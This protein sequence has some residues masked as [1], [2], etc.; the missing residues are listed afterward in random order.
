VQQPAKSISPTHPCVNGKRRPLEIFLLRCLKLQRTVRPLAVV[1]TNVD[2]E[3]ALE[4]ASG[5]DEQPVQAL[6][7]H[8]SDPSF[9]EGVGPRCPDGGADHLQALGYERVIERTTELGV[10]VVDE[11]PER[12]CP[13]VEAEGEVPRLLG[14]PGAVGVGGATGEMDPPCRELLVFIELHSAL[15]RKSSIVLAR[16]MN[17]QSPGRSLG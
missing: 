4:V 11:K 5:Q 2:P 7:P 9:A 13:L 8:R 15:V 6:G 17:P 12:L 16:V 14:N 1:M 10:A 3:D